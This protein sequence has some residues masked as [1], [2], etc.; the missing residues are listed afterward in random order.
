MT[1]SKSEVPLLVWPSCD[2]K[3]SDLKKE[4]VLDWPRAPP[5]FAALPS[6]EGADDLADREDFPDRAN[7][8]DDSPLKN[9]KPT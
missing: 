9:L 1:F 7:D 8:L 6:V 4:R 2:L 3:F 5:P